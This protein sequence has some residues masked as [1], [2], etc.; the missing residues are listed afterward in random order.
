MTFS[1]P[2]KL[3][4]VLAGSL[5]FF[6]P[7]VVGSP[8]G[9]VQEFFGMSDASAAVAISDDLFVAATDEDNQLRV[10]RRHPPGLAI[11][12][13]NLSPL[14]QMKKKAESDLEGA[15]RIG[16]VVYWIS[17]HG[18]NR[19]GQVDPD[20]HLLFGTRFEILPDGKV[21]VKVVGRPY[22]GL[23]KDLIAAPQLK[24]VNLETAA[25]LAPKDE[26]AL[27]IEGLCATPDGGLLIGFRNPIPDGLTL[28]VPLKNPQSLLEGKAAEFGEPIFLDLG[29]LGIRDMVFRN[30]SYILVAGSHEGTREPALFS[31]AGP[32]SK[33]RLLAHQALGKLNPEGI[34]F[35]PNQKDNEFQLLSDDSGRKINGVKGKDLKDASLK[36]F[37]SLQIEID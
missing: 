19:A 11:Q 22:R 17:S 34:F 16:D 6:K 30:G 15:A 31:W 37:R 35:Y 32:G 27:N 20:R 25:Q 26:G 29:G 23:V 9:S 12:V 2:I 28:L 33:P 5:L 1:P 36:R 21:A 13:L 8:V 14:L 24:K 3:S 10:F 4:L 7:V 18:R